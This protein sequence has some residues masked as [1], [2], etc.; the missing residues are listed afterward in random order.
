MYENSSSKRKQIYTKIDNVQKKS[1][2]KSYSLDEEQEE[3]ANSANQKFSSSDK[4]KPGSTLSQ[5]SEYERYKESKREY[6]QDE[7]NRA[8]QFLD[9]FLNQ[10]KEHASSTR[11]Q[12]A[13]SPEQLQEE[14]SKD[15]LY[16]DS[17][18]QSQKQIS[19]G[20]VKPQNFLGKQGIE[21]VERDNKFSQEAKH[22]YH[23]QQQPAQK[24]DR[25]LSPNSELSYSIS[26]IER[27]RRTPAGNR[28][29]L[30]FIPP[31]LSLANC[32]N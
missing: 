26:D 16:S 28:F 22:R 6:T 27:V 2:Q 3:M 25:N 15:S 30:S 31:L 1:D 29:S 21:S 13:A 5:R 24:N 19:T 10:H 8:N 7:L 18:Q 14:M 9:K 17:L 4:Y 11:K 20:M 12:K 23:V 32:L